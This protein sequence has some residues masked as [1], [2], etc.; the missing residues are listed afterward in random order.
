[1]PELASPHEH[2][3]SSYRDLMRRRVTEILLVSSQYDSFIMEEDGGLVEQISSKYLDLHLSRSPRLR[4]VSTASEA[5]EAL[6]RRRYD[7]VVTMKQ[8]GD[9]DAF[10]FGREVKQK[11]PGMPVVL[12]L[13]RMSDAVSSQTKMQGEGVD[14]VF[15]WS[16]DSGI[17]LAMIKSIEDGMNVDEDVATARVR[18]IVLVEDSPLHYSSFLP[19]LLGEVMRHCQAILP[20]D[21]NTMHRLYRM[22]ARP[23]IL[24]ARTYEEAHALFEKYRENILTVISD[25]Q[26]PKGGELSANAGT[27]LYE[28]VC[29]AGL[30]VPYLFLSA[31]EEYRPCVEEM[32][33]SF[34]SKHSPSLAYELRD[35]IA[36]RLGFGDFVFRMS[37]GQEVARAKDVTEFERLLEEIPDESLL[38][39]LGAQ[40]FSNWFMARGEYWLAE[41]VARQGPVGQ[42]DLA[43]AR[44]VLIETIAQNAV[45]RRKGRISDFSPEGLGQPSFL[46]RLG[47]GSVGGKARGL[48]FMAML[49]SSAKLSEDFGGVTTRI[50]RTVAISVDE[51]ERFIEDNGLRRFAFETF[52]DEEIAEAFLKGH[53]PQEM[54]EGMDSMLKQVRYPLAVRSSSLL[55]DS[56]NVPFAGIYSTHMLPNSHADENV[57]R[58]QLHRAVKLVYASVFFGNARRYLESVNVR[59]AEEKMGIII[60]EMVGRRHGSRFY[61]D[62]SGVAHSYNFYPTGRLTPED[63]VAHVALGLGRIVTDDG[64]ALRF[65]PAHPRVLPQFNTVR[66]YLDLTQRD[67]YAL[68]MSDPE[69]MPV[70]DD[71]A[72][73]VRCDLATAEK[74]GALAHV[75]AVY[76]REDDA[77]YEGIMGEGPRLVTFGNVLKHRS[78]PLP[79]MLKRLLDMGT[80]GMG[81]PVELEFA[82]TLP[83]PGSEGQPVFNLLQVRPMFASGEDTAVDLS[84]IRE[85]DVICR[86]RNTLSNGEIKGIRDV[87]YVR[88][89]DF[90]ELKTPQIAAEF[91]KINEELFARKCPYIAIGLGR[92]GTGEASLG[93]PVQ[94]PQICGARAL[95][96]TGRPGYI[97]DPSHGT[98]F[99]QNLT[100]L[101]VAYLNVHPEHDVMDWDWL[102]AQEVVLDCEFVR[103]V[104]TSCALTV[105]VDGRR[106]E[107]AILRE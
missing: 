39:H 83:E 24:L 14:R 57:R 6:S 74:D 15:M 25:I 64:E 8:L 28:E 9:M 101:R 51:F 95:V 65:S 32:G 102:D 72:D 49:L 58:E 91:G 42:G 27:H 60:Q 73:L 48:A 93:I 4:R 31:Q 26:L 1:M 21:I 34:I 88:P 107:G 67:F 18:V 61:P 87:V 62:I 59:I 85:A 103:H 37:N 70:I 47:R 63:G 96:E 104:R 97:I 29:G 89:V 30:D 23:K 33:A 90:N 46:M 10:T 106:R 55:E 2:P 20:E 86:S 100:S 44:N 92:W 82:V 105:L 19:M 41:V 71:G 11:H 22:R 7:L 69:V 38:H 3:Y 80:E 43:G 53:L 56:H 50:P 36:D 79:A 35:F 77:I 81:C 5:F 54:A 45:E 66:D 52:P 99:F 17:F 16:G 98:H 94:W 76:V 13:H 40:H 12:L 78:F 75:G 84:G 68:D